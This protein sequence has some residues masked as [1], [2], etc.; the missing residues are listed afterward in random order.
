MGSSAPLYDLPG[1]AVETEE[2]TDSKPH[3]CS[4]R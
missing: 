2:R 3:P 1:A 4:I